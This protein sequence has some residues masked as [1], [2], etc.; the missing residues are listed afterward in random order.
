MRVD[1]LLRFLKNRLNKTKPEITTPGK[2]STIPLK[3]EGASALS[4]TL[5]DMTRN[6]NMQE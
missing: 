3:D 6:C 4:L 1:E 2:V 5:Y